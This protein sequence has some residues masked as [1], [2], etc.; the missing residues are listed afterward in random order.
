MKLVW[1]DEWPLLRKLSM[2]GALAASKMTHPEITSASGWERSLGFEL[3]I[4]GLSRITAILKSR[5]N[6]YS[7]FPFMK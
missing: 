7:F 6:M 5:F 4:G 3:R 1:V 2:S